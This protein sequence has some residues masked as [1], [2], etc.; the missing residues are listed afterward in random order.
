[1]SRESRAWKIRRRVYGLVFLTVLIGL[2]SL[3]I[4][5]YRQVF[6]SVTMVT[7]D[8]D[9]TGAQL[10]PQADVKLR[11]IIV[12]QVRTISTYN[13]TGADG[14]RE[15]RARL[16]MALDPK[17]TK[18]I[19]R[20][21]SALLLPKTLF[22]ERYVALQI[23]DGLTADLAEPVRSGDTIEGGKDSIELERVLNDL[24]PVLLALHP[25]QLKST[26]TAF[27]TALQGRGKQLGDNLASLNAYLEQFNPKVPTL[28]DDLDKLGQVATLYNDAAPDLLGTLNNLQT[29]STTITSRTQALDQL[30]KSAT[31]ASNELNGFLN[32]SG[33]YLIQVASDGARILPVLA[34]YAPEYPCLAT[35]LARAEP[36]EEQLFGGG[37]PALHITMELVK[38]LGKYVPGDEPKYPGSAFASL[39]VAHCFGL[40]DPVNPFP[41]VKFPDGASDGAAVSAQHTA[42]R[43]AYNASGVG[44]PAES[45]LVSALISSSFGGNPADVPSI[46]T[47]LAAPLL[48]GSQVTVK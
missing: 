7:L 20:G 9:H 31:A 36:I 32:D 26:L 30:L 45:N 40:P 48:R 4:A 41:G 19:P 13:L 46:A 43:S 33:N 10:L 6:T 38:S 16:K 3:S 44:S 8:T 35:A 39:K 14:Q 28:I 15:T 12:G 1:M 18:L 47:I 34:K 2:L 27:A 25:E 11:G 24:Y 17:Q 21:A 5:S 37:Q 29:T 23:P 22:G 42:D